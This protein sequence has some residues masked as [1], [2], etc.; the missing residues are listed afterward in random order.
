MTNKADIQVK[1]IPEWRYAVQ[2]EEVSEIEYGSNGIGSFMI[3]TYQE[4]GLEKIARLYLDEVH[5]VSNLN[6]QEVYFHNFTA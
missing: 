1:F 2:F 4:D 3:I 5:T 6:G